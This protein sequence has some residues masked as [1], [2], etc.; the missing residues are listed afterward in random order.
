M[1]K[2]III[3]LL[4]YALT[5]LTSFSQG[6]WIEEEIDPDTGLRTGKI[7]IN[8]V[9]ATI[10]SGV[11]LSGINLEGADLKKANLERAILISS[12]FRG[13]NLTYSRLNSAD[14]SDAKISHYNT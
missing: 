9:I 2:P 13:A 3:A 5:N 14:F 8:G 7:E 12:N 1:K 4:Y 6:Q 11:D 10:N